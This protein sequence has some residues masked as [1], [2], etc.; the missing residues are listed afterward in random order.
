MEAL[1]LGWAAEIAKGGFG[2][3]LFMGTIFVL[4]RRD[5][6]L[7]ICREQSREDAIKMAIALEQAAKVISESSEVER[8]QIEADKVASAVLQALIKQI[9]VS[10]ER[11]RK[12]IDVSDDRA[13]DRAIN[14]KSDIESV[15][16]R[17]E[18]LLSR[19][20]SQN[21]RDQRGRSHHGS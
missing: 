13:K 12:Q 18:T 2:W 21:N 19:W 10:D 15:I 11:L 1:G 8:Q 17:V 14:I 3:L 7:R 16:T 9:D 5:E 4:W 20:P 6:S